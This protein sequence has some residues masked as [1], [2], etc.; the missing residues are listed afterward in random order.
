VFVGRNREDPLARIRS[1]TTAVEEE[2][3]TYAV[4][5]D[6]GLRIRVSG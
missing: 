5:D 3:P 1:W 4:I 6:P 2:A